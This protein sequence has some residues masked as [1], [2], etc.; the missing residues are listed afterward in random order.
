MSSISGALKR[1]CTAFVV[2]FSRHH[3]FC[4]SLIGVQPLSVTEYLPPAP[5]T[6]R[7]FSSFQAPEPPQSKG[8]TVYRDIDYSVGNTPSSRASLRNSDTEAVFVVSGASRGIGLQF[9]KSLISG[10]KGTVVACCRSPESASG[11]NE[12][13]ASMTSDDKQRIRV[14]ELNLEDQTSIELAAKEVKDNFK[15]V[16]L[17]LNVAGLLGDGHNTPGPERSIAKMDREW[18]EKTFNVNVVGPVMLSK[19]LAPLMAQRRGAKKDES[20]KRPN[21]VIANLSARVGSI[22][23]NQMGGWISYRMSKSALNQATRTMAHELKRQSI[24]CI[25]LH[26]GTTDTDLSKPFQKNVKEGRLFPV[27]FTVDSLLKVIDSMDDENSGGLYDWAGKAI[28]F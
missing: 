28:P 8:E 26:P 2:G 17:L 13:I 20:E 24:W 12:A 6:I 22:S 3:G 5:R 19:E 18:M 21:A 7:Q 16:D 15:R 4:R 1:S 23:D 14:V 9:V 11:L 25:A 10:T 27:D